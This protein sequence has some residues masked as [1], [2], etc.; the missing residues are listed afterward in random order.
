M[1]KNKIHQLF[2]VVFAVLIAAVWLLPM[3]MGLMNSVKT[4]EDIYTGGFLSFPR[5]IAIENYA[6][7][8]YKSHL[9]EYFKNSMLITIS[10]V[11]LILTL[12]CPAAYGFARN[13]FRGSSFIFMIFLSGLAIPLTIV[14]IPLYQLMDSFGLLDSYFGIIIVEASYCLAFS[15]FIMRNFFRGVPSSL[16]DAATVDGCSQWGIFLRIYLPLAKPALGALIVLTVT[17]IWN[18]FLFPL[19]LIYSKNKKPITLGLAQLHGEHISFWNLQMAG[20]VIAS[21]VPLAIFLAFQKYFARGL[22]TGAVKG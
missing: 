6:D 9:G 15:I 1:K 4:M 18:S 20:A 14:L 13:T 11:I 12:A 17:W 7:V 19:I 5:R 10:A 8:W 22:M 2:I 21:I 3:V 16:A